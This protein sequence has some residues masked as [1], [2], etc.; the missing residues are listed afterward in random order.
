VVSEASREKFG[1]LARILLLLRGFVSERQHRSVRAAERSKRRAKKWGGDGGKRLSCLE[2]SHR[3]ASDDESGHEP[4]TNWGTRT[5]ETTKRGSSILG[6]LRRRLL[7]RRGAGHYTRRRFC[8][9]FCGFA[10]E[11]TD[12]VCSSGGGERDSGRHD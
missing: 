3:G 10:R 7:T 8:D 2:F 11:M 12:G 9:L 5:S 6:I 4:T 1:D